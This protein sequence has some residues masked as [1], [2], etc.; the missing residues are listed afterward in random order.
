MGE[1]LAYTHQRR[2]APGGV[3]P[4]RAH[5]SSSK[6]RRP[7]RRRPTCARRP[8]RAILHSATLRKE[9]ACPLVDTA[10]SA[11]AGSG[12][13][14]TGSARTA[15]RPRPCATCS[16][17]SRRSR[18]GAVVDVQVPRPRRA[19]FRWWWRHSLW[20]AWTF[21]AGF[22]NW[23][24]FVYIGV[25][26]RHLPWSLLG[27]V[28]LMPLVLTILAIGTPLFQ[29]DGRRAARRLGGERRQRPV[30][31][32]LLPR[33]HVRRRA[34]ARA[35]GAAAAAV[36]AWRRPSGRSCPRAWTRRPPT[37]CSPRA[38][39]W[40][41]SSRAP[42]PSARRRCATTSSPC[43]APPTRSSPSWRRSRASS[44]RRAAF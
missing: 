5:A 24:A 38:G 27:F 35:A 4:R 6:R 21:T 29:V 8:L 42:A 12:S 17:S 34:A 28:Y 18:P 11:R 41:P 15:T 7:V 37:C 31:A 26:A 40:T 16:S 33:D 9:A 10:A 3:S 2:G 22:L 20:V 39:R 13:R 25:R 43:A 44:T 1:S 30:P 36:A 19:R 32:A 14:P 23:V